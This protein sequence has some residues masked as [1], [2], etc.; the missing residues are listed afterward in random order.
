MNICHNV[1][2]DEF[3]SV[4]CEKC[5]RHMGTIA[6]NTHAIINVFDTRD[7]IKRLKSK[8]QA[9]CLS[10]VEKGVSVYAEESG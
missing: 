5:G 4:F 1:N 8:T 10:C 2:E 7:G 6:A 9:L 3:T